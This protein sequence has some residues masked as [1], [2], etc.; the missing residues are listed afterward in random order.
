MAMSMNRNEPEGSTRSQPSSPPHTPIILPTF[1]SKNR[2]HGIE[3]FSRAI[4]TQNTH[5]GATTSN[6]NGPSFSFFQFQ[7]LDG[8]FS[9]RSSSP[10]SSCSS[11][12]SSSKL[13][14]DSPRPRS[15]SSSQQAHL[16]ST[17]ACNRARIITEGNFTVEEAED[18][19]YD[20]FDSDAES[21]IRPHEYEDGDSER[22]RS[23]SPKRFPT[24]QELD[25]Q[26]LIGLQSLNCDEGDAS[27]EKEIWLQERREERRRKR[28]S[29]GSVQKRSLA[30]SI[31]SDTDDEDVEFLFEGANE[32]GS[33]ARRLRR[34]VAGERASL[35]FDNPPPRIEEL[36]EL[37]SHE[38]VVS[39]G[40]EDGEQQ[41]FERE[42][43]YYVYD[44]EVDSDSDDE[45]LQQGFSDLVKPLDYQIQD[46]SLG[47]LSNPP[48]QHFR[49]ISTSRAVNRS[50]TD[51][52]FEA[53]NKNVFK[54]GTESTSAGSSYT[55]SKAVSSNSTTRK[56]RK[57]DTEEQEDDDVD[58]ASDHQPPNGS[59]TSERVLNK[60]VRFACPF[61]KFDPRKYNIY[62]HRGVC[63]ISHWGTISRVKYE[64]LLR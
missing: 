42:L 6:S 29:S 39:L 45:A 7:A 62:L 43:P 19:D 40:E 2:R 58:G 33:S 34:K 49:T 27:N 60:D 11:S 54:C 48:T 9:P 53:E 5:I 30:Q 38:K 3:G 23:R 13:D 51:I 41:G 22:A 47:L 44:M 18:G 59:K 61:R 24:D 57:V 35:A 21:A 46:S 36:D 50:H 20:G 32:A 8:K 15:R 52:D 17:K 16:G 56:R 1:S 37:E 64:D 31:G 14:V 25:P 63:A 10:A 28:R 26:I 55:N 4:S 12:S